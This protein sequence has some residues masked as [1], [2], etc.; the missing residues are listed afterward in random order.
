MDKILKRPELL[1]IIIGFIFGLAFLLITPKFGVADESGHYIRAKEV[2]QGILYNNPNDKN[3]VF[4]NISGYSPVMYIFSGNGAKLAEKINPKAEFYAGRL[5]NLIVWCLLMALAIHI[6]PIFKWMFFFAAL[7][8][9]SVYEGMSYSADSFSNAFSFLFFAYVF[10]LIFPYK[11]FSYKKD[12]PL[13]FIF[14]IIGAL[15]KGIVSPVFL[16]FFLP[17]KKFKYPICFSL[18]IISLSIVY[19]WSSS[20]SAAIYPGVVPEVNKHFILSHPI[21]YLEKILKTVVHFFPNYSGQMIGRLGPQSIL[22]NK[23][24]YQLTA[25]VFLL[26][27]VFIPQKFEVK[28]SL[29]A[30]SFFIIVF[31]VIMTFTL[32]FVTWTLFDAKYIEGVQGRYFIAILPLSFLLFSRSSLRIAP[33]P[34]MH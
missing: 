21:L 27:F 31:Y 28:P 10:K 11:P 16:L 5:S 14:T 19:L 29:R 4:T 9:M 23:T 34:E 6:T 3:K 17:I 26:S 8:P 12:V 7:L 15:C 33:P 32:M 20:N 1:F 13:L 2:S 25:L 22:L 24:I 18:L 30:A